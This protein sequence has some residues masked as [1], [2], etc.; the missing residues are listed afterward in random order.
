M[1][2]KPDFHSSV[3]GGLTLVE[4]LVVLGVVAVLAVL[5]EPSLSG[6]LSRA[7]TAECATKL[8][9]LG[10][11]IHLYALEN[12]GEFPRSFHSAGSYG[13]PGWT[14]S[15]FPY[16]SVGTGDLAPESFEHLY[17]CPAHREKNP[18]IFSY[19]M[20]VHFELDPNGDDYVGSPASWRRVNL[21]PS[22][23]KT[24]LLGETRPILFGDHLMCH[25]W[26]SS[27][28]A[29]NALASDRH[30]GMPSFLFVDGHVEKL[31]PEQT[32][33]PTKKLNRWN[34]SLA[35]SGGPG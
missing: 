22:P 17:R 9:S 23:S 4:A 5:I 30:G 26:S 13:Q 16:L 15:I 19:G 29:K 18:F 33:D 34:P 7:E 6:A 25:Q 31:K 27:L 12:Q 8:R 32:L 11:A 3:R 14:A 28:A 20:N 2:V 24:I 1:P 10:N 21:V 35:G